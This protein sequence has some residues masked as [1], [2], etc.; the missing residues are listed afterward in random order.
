MKKIITLILFFSLTFFFSKAQSVG[1]NFDGVNDYISTNNSGVTGNGARTVEA[2]IKTTANANPSAGGLQKVICDWGSATTGGRYTLNLL[3]SNAIRIEVQGSGLSDTVPINDGIWHH[4]AAVYNPSATFK[5]QLY[6]DGVLH[7][8]GNITTTV[9]TSTLNKI[10]IGRRVD[11]VNY[12]AGDID[13]VRVFNYARTGVEIATERFKEFCNVPSSLVAYYKL[14]EGIENGANSSNIT[15]VDYSALRQAG[16]LQNFMLSGNTSNWTIGAPIDNGIKYDTIVATA[17]ISY[18]SPSGTK[19][20]TTSGTYYDTLSTVAGCD[21]LFTIFLTIGQTNSSISLHSCGDYTSPSGK[22]FTQNGTYIDTILNS[23]GCDSIITINLTVGNAFATQNITAC[24]TYTSPSGHSYSVSGTITDTLVGASMFGCDSIITINLTMNQSVSIYDTLI[25]CDSTFVN[26]QWH[27]SST[28]LSDTSLSSYACDSFHHLVIL[29]NYSSPVTNLSPSAC[30]SY[31]SP[32]GVLY[33]TS[34]TFIETFTNIN[35]CD[36]IVVLNVTIL[37][38]TSSSRTITG[39]DSIFINNTKYT[40]SQTLSITHQGSNS[41]DSVETIQLVINRSIQTSSTL[42]GCDSVFYN[43]LWYHSSQT[44]VSNYTSAN[45][46]DSTHT[47]T[48]NISSVD[49]T[50]TR[51]GDTLT[52]NQAGATYKWVN[53]ATNLLIGVNTQSFTVTTPGSYKVIITQGACTDTSDCIAI[54]GMDNVLSN[55]NFAIA[56]NPNNGQFKLIVDSQD[57]LP[58]QIIDILCKIIYTG[59]TFGNKETTINLPIQSGF[60]TVIVNGSNNRKIVIE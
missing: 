58:I 34:G 53:C 36:S 52:A 54:S 60:Y 37:S 30:I 51:N 2:W 27:Y 33:T 5:H 39:C 24:N 55:I 50:V 4:V 8:Q 57:N 12:F 29:I 1:V 21:S 49:K 43:G 23:T 10:L 22:I 40:T 59:N 38:P 7:V 17:C 26:N 16:T 6:V 35:G 25:A 44:V 31:T 18:S 13:E 41:C 48:I 19:T 9:N 32:S 46:C 45:G 3:W 47:T 20:W 11:A 28:I 15:A 56:P 14:N 42:N